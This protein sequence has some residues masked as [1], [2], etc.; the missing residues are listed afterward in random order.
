MPESVVGCHQG[1]GVGV[2]EVL[3]ARAALRH[4]I[5]SSGQQVGSHLRYSDPS[6]FSAVGRTWLPSACQP[7]QIDK[8]VFHVDP[9]PMPWQQ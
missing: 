6:R 7:Q 3:L 9:K 2:I 8:R 4:L 1:S 5:E